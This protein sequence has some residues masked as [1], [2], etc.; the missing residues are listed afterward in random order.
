[1][2]APYSYEPDFYCDQK[3]GRSLEVQGAIFHHP[4]NLIAQAFAQRSEET[5]QKQAGAQ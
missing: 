3:P 5:F 2:T 4:G 1:M